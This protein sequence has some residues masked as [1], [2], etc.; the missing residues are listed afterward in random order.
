MVSGN[1]SQSHGHFGQIPMATPNLAMQLT[2]SAQFLTQAL[3]FQ[4]MRF[5]QS[6]ELLLYQQLR[7]GSKHGSSNKK[8]LMIDGF[9]R[10]WG[11]FKT[12]PFL[13]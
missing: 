2:F 1:W 10:L 3:Q 5:L 12:Q 7:K 11:N 9:V 13:Y 6:L 8:K 4:A